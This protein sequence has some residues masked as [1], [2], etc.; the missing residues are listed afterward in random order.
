MDS[1][2]KPTT[3]AEYIAQ[4]DQ[5]VQERLNALRRVIRETAPEA[6][7]KISWGMPTYVLRRNLVHFAV[8]QHHIGFYPGPT[9]VE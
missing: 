3:V 8:H 2:S 7:E 4:F 9:G 5:P 6:I 1:N